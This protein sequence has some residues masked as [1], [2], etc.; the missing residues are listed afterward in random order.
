VRPSHLLTAHM[1]STSPSQG[2]SGCTTHMMVYCHMVCLWH[3]YVALCV[4]VYMSR[5]RS[6][7]A[8]CASIGACRLRASQET[9]A[10]KKQSMVGKFP[11]DATAILSECLTYLANRINVQPHIECHAHQTQFAN[12]GQADLIRRSVTIS[13]IEPWGFRGQE[14]CR[15]CVR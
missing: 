2:I 10:K 5:R 12:N 15:Q 4:I 11:D 3:S 13:N 14:A 6:K 1:T 8:P 7:Q 9:F